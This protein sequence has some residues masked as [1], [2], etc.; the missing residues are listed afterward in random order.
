MKDKGIHIKFK[1]KHSK[2]EIMHSSTPQEE[3]TSTLMV[4][5]EEE[6]EV[7]VWVEVEVRLFVIIAHNQDI[8]QGIVRTFVPLATIVIRLTM[9]LNIVQYCWPNSRRDKEETNKY[10]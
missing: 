5:S 6:D 1:E 2:K 3:E 7:E 10:N 8:W 4:N 9:S